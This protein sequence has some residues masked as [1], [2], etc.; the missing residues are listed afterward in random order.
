MNRIWLLVVLVLGVFLYFM[1]KKQNDPAGLVV[2]EKKIEQVM[3]KVGKDAEKVATTVDDAAKKDASSAAQTM[4]VVE[5]ASIEVASEKEG[6][7]GG[8]EKKEGAVQNKP[9]GEG[10]KEEKK[11]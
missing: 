11:D 6:K 5:D 9:E 8:D 1:Y 4:A 3:E 2:E 10:K 7:E